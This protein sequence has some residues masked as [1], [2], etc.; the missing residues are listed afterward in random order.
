MTSLFQF[1]SMYNSDFKTAFSQIPQRTEGT[2]L[3]A[4]SDEG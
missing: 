1:M 2:A 3:E 4:G